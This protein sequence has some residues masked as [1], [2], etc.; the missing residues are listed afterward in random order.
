MVSSSRPVL[1]IRDVCCPFGFS[2]LSMPLL[3][4]LLTC[5]VEEEKCNYFAY[6]RTDDD[7]KVNMSSRY[8]G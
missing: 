2:Y 6:G 7:N 3:S 1:C 8:I 5:Y 4:K